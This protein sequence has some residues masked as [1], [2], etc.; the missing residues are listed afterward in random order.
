V[1]CLNAASD[2]LIQ[3]DIEWQVVNMNRIANK[4]MGALG[5]SNYTEE[6]R[7]GNGGSIAT[8]HAPSFVNPFLTQSRR[9]PGAGGRGGSGSSSLAQAHQAV[10]KREKD[11]TLT[12]S[13]SRNQNDV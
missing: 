2:S 13:K 6:S 3:Y 1:F 10:E 9:G 8:K 11:R 12:Y 4:A 5:G 7:G